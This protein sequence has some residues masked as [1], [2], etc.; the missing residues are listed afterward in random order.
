MKIINIFLE[1]ETLDDKGIIDI[2]EKFNIS[3]KSQY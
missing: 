2:E 1:R 3:R